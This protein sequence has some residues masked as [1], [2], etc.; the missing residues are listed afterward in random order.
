VHFESYTQLFT[1]REDVFMLGESSAEV[2]PKIFDVFCLI[3]LSFVYLDWGTCFCTC[4]EYD[5]SG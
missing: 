2:Q 5:M 1:F 4:G 3:E